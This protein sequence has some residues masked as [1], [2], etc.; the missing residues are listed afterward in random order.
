[1]RRSWNGSKLAKIGCVAL[2]SDYEKMQLCLRKG[3]LNLCPNNSHHVYETLM[4]MLKCIVSA[5]GKVAKLEDRVSFEFDQNN[6]LSNGLHL[7]KIETYKEQVFCS[8]APNSNYACNT[9]YVSLR[10]SVS[11]SQS[12]QHIL[13]VD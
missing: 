4:Q 12:P 7:D 13:F 3:C 6:H 1:M 5:G 9:S 8:V 11:V 2:R 10:E